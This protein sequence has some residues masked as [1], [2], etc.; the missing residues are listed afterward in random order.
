MADY[1]VLMEGPKVQVDQL[2]DMFSQQK[3]GR[4]IR[5]YKESGPMNLIR[6]N[7]DGTPF[8]DGPPIEEFELDMGGFGGEPGRKE[9]FRTNLPLM[10]EL[11]KQRGL[12]KVAGAT[13]G[14][15]EASES[16]SGS[17]ETDSETDDGAEGQSCCERGC[18]GPCV[19]P[20]GQAAFDKATGEGAASTN[21][22]TPKNEDHR[23]SELLRLSSALKVS[24]QSAQP[25][26]HFCVCEIDH[27]T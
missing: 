6:V 5:S 15:S 23:D 17:Y 14:I 16:E 24:A 22:V 18:C 9:T 11:F 1:K 21:E 10:I 27:L 26:H 2:Y 20:D 4:Y 12:K 25:S 19:E 8:L 7:G 3:A 13:G